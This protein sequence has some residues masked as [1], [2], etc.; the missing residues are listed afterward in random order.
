[1]L[2]VA[3]RRIHLDVF[4]ACQIVATWHSVVLHALELQLELM[5]LLEQKILPHIRP[6][7]TYESDTS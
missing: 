7:Q 2:D 4:D 1:M 5:S 6:E 3:Q